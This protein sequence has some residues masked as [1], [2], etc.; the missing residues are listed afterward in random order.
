MQKLILIISVCSILCACEEAIEPKSFYM[1]N[2]AARKAKLV[3]CAD[4]P[5]AEYSSGNCLNA[6]IALQEKIEALKD[7]R[8]L[9]RQQRW[10]TR[11]S[12]RI[13]REKCGSAQNTETYKSCIDVAEKESGQKH[14]EMTAFNAETDSLIDAL[15]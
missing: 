5:D 9:I 14:E 8:K 1:E 10:D 11:S 12:L 3:W 7:N 6:G 15:K 13:E 2:D 4:H